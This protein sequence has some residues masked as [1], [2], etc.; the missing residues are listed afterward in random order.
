V[1]LYIICYDKVYV[2]YMYTMIVLKK[3]IDFT[4]N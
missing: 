2:F 1:F 4:N 3:Y